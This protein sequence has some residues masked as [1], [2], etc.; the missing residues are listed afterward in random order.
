M[1]HCCPTC[2]KQYTDAEYREM[3]SEYE[4]ALSRRAQEIMRDGG[5][6]LITAVAM[7]QKEIK[8]N[9]TRSGQAI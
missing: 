6:D 2:G 8:S 7:A 9:V 4:S 1:I 5:L 3:R